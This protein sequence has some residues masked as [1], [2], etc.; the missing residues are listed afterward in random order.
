MP[1]WPN[2]RYIEFCP[3]EW[4]RTRARLNDAEM[5]RPLG[6]ISVPSPPSAEEQSPTS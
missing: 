2:D 4:A 3:K 5:M 1:Y 6:H